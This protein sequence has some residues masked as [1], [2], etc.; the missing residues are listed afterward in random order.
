MSNAERR[1][2]YFLRAHRFGG[3]SFR[4]QALIGP[5]IVDFVCHDAG[6]IIELD[7]GQHGMPKALRHDERRTAWLTARGYNV[8]RFWNNDVLRNTEG[9]LELIAAELDPNPPPCS[10]RGGEQTSPSRGEVTRGA[11]P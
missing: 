9:V 2:W 5:Y 1:L 10:P 7:G 8:L 3:V 11:T 6:L 4:R